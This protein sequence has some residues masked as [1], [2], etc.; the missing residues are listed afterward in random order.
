MS[1]VAYITIWGQFSL[2]FLSTK[3]FRVYDIP[4]LQI[5]ANNIQEDL[6]HKLIQKVESVI[7]SNYY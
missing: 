4:D 3:H 7:M 5:Y 1:N 6:A 2:A